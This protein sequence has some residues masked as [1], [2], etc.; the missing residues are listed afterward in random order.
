MISA[1][2]TLNI[3]NAIKYFA[4]SRLPEL[5]RSVYFEFGVEMYI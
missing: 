1:V 5:G 2:G 4:V 3:E